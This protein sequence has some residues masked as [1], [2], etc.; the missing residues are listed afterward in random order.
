MRAKAWR[1]LLAAK[2]Q[3]SYDPQDRWYARARDIAHGRVDFETRSLVRT[4]LRPRLTVKKS[5]RWY[6]EERD[7]YAPETLRSLLWIDFEPSEQVPF[8]EI[9]KTW[10][11]NTAEEIALYRVLERALFDVLEEAEDAGALEGW[12]IY[13]S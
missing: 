13:Q 1:V 10:P 11:K 9:V 8:D 12:D 3:R 4:I 2:R 7:A 5:L 6:D